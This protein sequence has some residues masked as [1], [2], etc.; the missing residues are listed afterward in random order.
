MWCK[1]LHAGLVKANPKK[2]DPGQQIWVESDLGSSVGFNA[3]AVKSGMLLNL[4]TA[5][6]HL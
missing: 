6:L 4:P 1:C 3:T 5:Q 2:H